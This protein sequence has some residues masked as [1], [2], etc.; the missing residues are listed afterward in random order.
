[1]SNYNELVFLHQLSTPCHLALLAESIGFKTRVVK[2]ISELDSRLDNHSF[3]FIAQQGAALDKHGIPLVVSQ[4]L[5][6]VP[7]AL[8]L[9][10]SNRIHA[11]SALLQGIRGLLFADQSVGQLQIGLR[12]IINDELWYDRQLISKVFRDLVHSKDRG[13]EQAKA[14]IT[15]AQ[16]FT[17]RERSVIQLV[18]KGARNKEIA[19]AL[20]ISEHTVKSHISSLFRKTGSRNRVELLRWVNHSSLISADKLVD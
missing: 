16:T 13:I 20:F 5:S 11:E 17:S 10:E 8:Y 12:K 7:V 14:R 6:H 15:I 4:L 2:Q 18:A 19:D 3:Y 1:M 9:I